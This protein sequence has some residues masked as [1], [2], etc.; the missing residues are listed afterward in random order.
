LHEGDKI[1]DAVAKSIDMILAKKGIEEVSTKL[2]GESDDEDDDFMPVT[3]DSA[4]ADKDR[5]EDDDHDELSAANVSAAV[6]THFTMRHRHAIL[7]FQLL[8]FAAASKEQP[9]QKT[10]LRLFHKGVSQGERAHE[11]LKCDDFN[12]P[13]VPTHDMSTF[14][15]EVDP[16]ILPAIIALDL[17]RRVLEEELSKAKFLM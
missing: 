16:S 13:V 5:D 14:L 6:E 9:S 15:G 12:Y 17:F 4:D 10:L 7:G 2:E 11:T 3:E 1:F 8:L